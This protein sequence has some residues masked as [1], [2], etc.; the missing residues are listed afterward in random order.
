MPLTKSPPSPRSLDGQPL[1]QMVMNYRASKILLVAVY[2]D[3]FTLISGGARQLNQICRRSKTNPRGTEVLL[4]SLVSLGFLKKTSDIYRNTP[5]SEKFLVE[6]KPDYLGNNLKYQEIIW[7]AWSELRSV[8]QT[9]K[10]SRSLEDWLFRDKAFGPEYIQG[11]DNIAK[12][13]AHE[14][15]QLFPSNGA[16]RLLDV[17]AGPG[18]Y[19]L[20]FLDQ[21]PSLE[22]FLLDLP[23]TV[24][25]ARKIVKSHPKSNRVHFIPG[26][27][28]HSEFGSDL[29]DFVILSHITHNEGE[30]DN[31]DLVKK[32]YEALQPGGSIVIHDFMTNIEKTAP[33]FAALFSVHMLVYT[34]KGK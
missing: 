4:D 31:K 2:F 21:H 28:H 33:L 32:A 22:A 24:K 3:F 16:R 19:A 12:Q 30:K 9:G 26:D 20:A 8:L 5:I 15:A 29:Y 11:M 34:K 10:V 25:I 23:T 14:I 6:G 1:I 18:T 17:G 27:Y 7:E 13:P